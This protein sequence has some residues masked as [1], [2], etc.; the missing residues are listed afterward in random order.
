ML[1][2][3]ARDG[4]VGGGGRRVEVARRGQVLAGLGDGRVESRAARSLVRGQGG[5][6]EGAPIGGPIEPPFRGRF[7]RTCS[8]QFSVAPPG[9]HSFGRTATCGPV[10][11]A[12]KVFGLAAPRREKS[13]PEAVLA[14][15]AF[16]ETRRADARGAVRES[17][18]AASLCIALRGNYWLAC[19]R[20]NVHARHE[21]ANADRR[22]S[23]PT[24]SG[25]SPL[26]RANHL[27]GVAAGPRRH[28]PHEAARRS[29]SGVASAGRPRDS[30]ADSRAADERV[31]RRVAAR[32]VEHDPSPTTARA[33]HLSYRARAINGVGVR[34]ANGE[35]IRHARAARDHARS[36]V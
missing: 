26:G 15:L 16:A 5:C 9:R 33:I 36:V 28:A 23:N 4:Q 22:F 34:I 21:F 2:L 30:C 1:Q 7:V 11:G 20:A 29:R 18:L 13:N 3:L 24:V 10:V 35:C 12:S 6:S 31:L 8:N 27:A 14:A 32:C 25:S 17:S 19:R